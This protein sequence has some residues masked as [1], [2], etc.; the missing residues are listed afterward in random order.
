MV[1]FE[2]N[3]KGIKEFATMLLVLANNY[4]EGQEYP[5]AHVN[6]VQSGC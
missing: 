6:Q 3:Y 2:I 4:K 1:F 5:L